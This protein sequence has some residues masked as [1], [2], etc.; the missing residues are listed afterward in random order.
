MR[1]MAENIRT[2]DVTSL[3]NSTAESSEPAPTAAPTPQC[4]QQDLE[5]VQINVAKHLDNLEGTLVK[6][7]IQKI[8]P[9]AL[10]PNTAHPDLILSENLTRMTYVKNNPKRFDKYGSAL[11]SVGFN[12]GT[13]S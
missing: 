1:A 5:T 7:M 13:H 9:V 4:T 12:S 8:A 3:H 2:D 6:K 10:D 11:G